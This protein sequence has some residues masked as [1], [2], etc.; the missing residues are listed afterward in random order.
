MKLTVP[1]GRGT[2]TIWYQVDDHKYVQFV[3]LWNEQTIELP[4]GA[5][6]LTLKDLV[7]EGKN[8]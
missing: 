2:L 7:A 3:H 6:I 1:S 4:D 8:A 5:K